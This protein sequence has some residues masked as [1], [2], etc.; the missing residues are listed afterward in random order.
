MTKAPDPEVEVNRM[1][2]AAVV[3]EARSNLYALKGEQKE[4]LKKAIEICDDALEV[5]VPEDFE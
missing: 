3:D 5:D 2:L 4:E 1:A